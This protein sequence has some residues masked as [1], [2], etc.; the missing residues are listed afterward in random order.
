MQEI[1]ELI[2]KVDFPGAVAL[3]LLNFTLKNYSKLQDKFM[4]KD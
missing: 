4:D 2:S 1:L 3:I